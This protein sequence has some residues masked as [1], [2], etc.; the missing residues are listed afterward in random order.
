M[1]VYFLRRYAFQQSRLHLAI[2]RSA[3]RERERAIIGII[4][5]SGVKLNGSMGNIA[6]EAVT[7]PHYV[8]ML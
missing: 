2:A 5:T 7:R 6:A 1:Y 8:T 3:I 4:T